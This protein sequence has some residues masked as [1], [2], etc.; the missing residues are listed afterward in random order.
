MLKYFVIKFTL[1]CLVMAFSASA[2]SAEVDR[3]SRIKAAFALNVSRFVTW[4]EGTFTRVEKITL[5]LFEDNFLGAA[6]NSLIGQKIDGL[7]LVVN[8]QI[9]L[10]TVTDCQII[11]VAGEK[12]E[13]LAVDYPQITQRPVL[14]IIDNTDYKEASI[15]Q[16]IAMVSLIRKGS[17]IGFDV[18]LMQVEAVNLK[19]SSKL[20]KLTRNI[21]T[22]TK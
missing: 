20:L 7:P 18:N 15:E 11:F 6:K 8:D 9:N 13:K 3:A 10:E 19:M 5:C 1:L 14:V 4:P 2:E 16:S 17:S 21:Y 12:L 22:S